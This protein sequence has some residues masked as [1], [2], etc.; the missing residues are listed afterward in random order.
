MQFLLKSIVFDLN[1]MTKGLIH[2]V[3]PFIWKRKSGIAFMAKRNVLIGIEAGLVKIRHVYGGII[4]K[5]G[6]KVCDVTHLALQEL[7]MSS[8]GWLYDR[9]RNEGQFYSFSNIENILRP[10]WNSLMSPRILRASAFVFL[11]RYDENTQIVALYFFQ[12]WYCRK[13]EHIVT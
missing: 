2:K 3:N 6:G 1:N 4:L 11:L 9:N 13:S 12:C 7:D 10:S 5:E 8:H